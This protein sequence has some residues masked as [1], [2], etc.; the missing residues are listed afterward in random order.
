M[1]GELFILGSVLSLSALIFGG[2]G[3]S[4]SQ[5]RSV[6]VSRDESQVRSVDVS[7]DDFMSNQHIS[8][9]AEVA[10]GDLFRVTLCSNQTTGFSWSE[11]VQIGDETIVEQMGHEFV[12][13]QNGQLVGAAGQEVW[14]FKAL[15]EGTTSIS[16]E[17]SQPWE[18][19]TKA[20]WTFELTVT[21]K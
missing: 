6:D 10:V 4:T 12:A 19:G 21:V 16:V 7:C 9:E 2:C 1:K 3:P 11:L 18:D 20:E 14:T 15:K 17:Y 5:E 13:P 8:R